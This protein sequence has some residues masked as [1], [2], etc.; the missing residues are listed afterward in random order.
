MLFYLN[1]E[2][3]VTLSRFELNKSVH[4]L[5]F[6]KIKVRIASGECTRINRKRERKE[7]D[8]T[9][10]PF[11]GLRT[12]TKLEFITKEQDE[13]GQGKWEGKQE[14]KSDKSI[15]YPYK[16]NIFRRI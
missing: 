8:I 11:G 10:T 5:L 16:P 1:C 6:K 12:R 9:C 15:T 4:I 2:V 3:P 14:G 13:H 7:S